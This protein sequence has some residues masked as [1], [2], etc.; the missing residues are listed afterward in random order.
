M[1]VRLDMPP[2]PTGSEKEQLSAVRDYLFVMARKL[3]AALASLDGASALPETA[4]GGSAAQKDGKSALPVSPEEIEAC[5][6]ICEEEIGAV[7][8]VRAYIAD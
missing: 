8:R 3:N 6:R 1:S 5:R 2:L 4:S 7:Y